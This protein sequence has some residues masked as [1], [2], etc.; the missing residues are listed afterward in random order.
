MKIFKL[1]KDKCYY[2]N[3]CLTS[4]YTCNI[5][6]VHGTKFPQ[7]LI[8]IFNKISFSKLITI[9]L[10]LVKLINYLHTDFF[11]MFVYQVNILQNLILMQGTK[12]TQSLINIFN[13]KFYL[14]I[15][16]VDKQIRIFDQNKKRQYLF[17]VGWQQLKKKLS[18]NTH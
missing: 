3:G 2:F 7:T 9:S 13:K 6:L 10:K 14:F 8:N 17:K 12:F 11:L 4:K 1:F 15:L 5:I 18:L 16:T